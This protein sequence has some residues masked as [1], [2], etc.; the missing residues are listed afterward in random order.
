MAYVLGARSR[1]NLQYVHPTLV[2]VVRRAIQLTTQDFTVLEGIRSL[3]QQRIY[4]DTGVSKTMNSMHLRQN[5]GYGHAVDLVPFVGG[6]LRWEWGP[7]YPVAAAMQ[8]A[9]AELGVTITWGG[10]WDRPMNRITGSLADAADE[11][12]KR[13]P[14]PDFLDGPHYEIHV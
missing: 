7:I 11:Y 4:V 5:D 8:A 13:H 10:V 6:V 14:G 9:A 2:G 3:A 12:A 1:N